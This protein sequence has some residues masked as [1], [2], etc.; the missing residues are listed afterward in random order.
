MN[1]MELVEIIGPGVSAFRG[2]NTK[3]GK[4]GDFIYA[5]RQEAIP[6]DSW[7]CAEHLDRLT[8]QDVNAAQKL[9]IEILKLDPTL[10]TGMDKR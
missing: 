10:V 3:S 6:A 7:L 9:F 2:K 1:D 5:V 4:L 8:R